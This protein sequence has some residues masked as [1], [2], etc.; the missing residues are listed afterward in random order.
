MPTAKTKRVYGKS[1]S[2]SPTKPTE[3]PSLEEFLY[4]LSEDEQATQVNTVRITD[5]GSIPQ[6]VKVQVEGIPAYG[7]IDSGTDITII[8][9]SLFKKVATVAQLKR[10]GFKKS[11]V[12]QRT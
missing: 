2:H 10:Q 8:G 7:L 6:C 1:K 3:E 5:K 4:S 12:V 9:G 11:D